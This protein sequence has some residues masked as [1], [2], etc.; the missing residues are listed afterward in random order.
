MA[1]FV[2]GFG[3]VGLAA[4]AAIATPSADVA[5]AVADGDGA[6]GGTTVVAVAAVLTVAPTTDN[7]V[8][9]S[10]LPSNFRSSFIAVLQTVHGMRFSRPDSA[11]YSVFVF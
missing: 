5:A 8:L 9:Q 4:A 1:V 7:G 3:V 11:D 6:V 2:V 10:L